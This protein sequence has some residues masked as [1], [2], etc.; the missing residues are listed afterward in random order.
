MQYTA[1][2]AGS[3][4]LP[5]SMLGSFN[6]RQ[7][8]GQGLHT[9]RLGSCLGMNMMLVMLLLWCSSSSTCLTVLCLPSSPQKARPHQLG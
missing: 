8:V 1:H 2:K 5:C 3:D 4:A 7:L 6:Q 9:R